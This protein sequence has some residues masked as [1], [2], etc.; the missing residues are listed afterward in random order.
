MPEEF[1]MAY[2]EIESSELLIVIGS[3]LTVSPVNYLPT[4]AKRLVIINL[5]ET[6]LDSRAEL[7]INENSTVVLKRVWEYING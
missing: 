7:V 4:T 5:T 2:E 6:P 3:S 1:Q